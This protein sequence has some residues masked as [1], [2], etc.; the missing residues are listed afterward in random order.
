MGSEIFRVD[1]FSNGS[2][3]TTLTVTRGQNGTTAVSHQEQLPIYGTAIEVTTNLTL[4]KTTGTYQSTPGLFDIQLN[5]VIIG[6]RLVLL[7]EL[8][9]LRFIKILQ[10]MS[11]SDR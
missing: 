7:L 10:Q 4:S 5:D 1:S 3:S 6:A 2:D 9:L 11:L 8:L